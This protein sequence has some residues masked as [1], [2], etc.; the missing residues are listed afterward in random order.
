MK[1]YYGLNT[2]ADELD[3]FG[4]SGLL[5]FEDNYFSG[6]VEFGTNPGGLEDVTISDGC[7]R[8]IPISIAYVPQ[9]ISVLKEMQAIHEEISEGERRREEVESGEV[10]GSICQYGHIHY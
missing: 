1:I 8:S 6:A 5:E 7:G 4:T 9:L 2:D 3:M 10:N